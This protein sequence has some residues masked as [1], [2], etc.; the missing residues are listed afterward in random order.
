[1]PHQEF[2]V[3]SGHATRNLHGF[4]VVGQRSKQSKRLDPQTLRA[5]L[6][7]ETVEGV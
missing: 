7:T 2:L 3:A 6:C 5:D 1:M 4:P